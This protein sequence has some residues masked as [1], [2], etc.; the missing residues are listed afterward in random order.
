MKDCFSH[1][2]LHLAAFLNHSDLI[3]YLHH[4]GCDING[5]DC[6]HHTP[7]HLAAITDSVESVRVLIQCGAKVDKFSVQNMTPIMIAAKYNSVAVLR[8]F[9]KL[10][11]RSLLVSTSDVKT[12]LMVGIEAKHEFIVNSLLLTGV[13]PMQ[14]L[15]NGWST[16]H[17]A[18][19]S[20]SISLY[21][22]LKAAFSRAKVVFDVN[23]LCQRMKESKF[24]NLHVFSSQNS[25][26][27]ISTKSIDYRFVCNLVFGVIERSLGE[28]PSEKCEEIPSKLSN[29]EIRS[30]FSWK[31]ADSYVSIYFSNHPLSCLSYRHS[32]KTSESSIIPQHSSVYDRDFCLHI[33][34][35][36]NYTRLIFDILEDIANDRISTGSMCIN[37]TDYQGMRP[38]FYAIFH[39]NEEVVEKLIQY[40]ADVNLSQNG[41][42]PLHFAIAAQNDRI[43]RILLVHKANISSIVV[44]KS[45]IRLSPLNVATL[46][47]NRPIIFM[48]EKAI[49]R[50]R[51]KYDH[52]EDIIIGSLLSKPSYKHQKHQK[53]EYETQSSDTQ[54][55]VETLSSEHHHP[56]VSIGTVFEDKDG[57]AETLSLSE[58]VE[59]LSI[60]S[61]KSSHYKTTSNIDAGI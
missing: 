9:I 57:E 17:S 48:I 35:R 10:C 37:L 11:D 47:M 25:E 6:D 30:V 26:S 7:L 36:H 20:G 12:A 5:I 39:G 42:F 40:G 33:A 14:K 53:I 18:A 61:V 22:N 23:C 13:C 1:S 54:E 60:E 21:R 19:L 31:L 15:S 59:I 27:K 45:G 32:Q 24:P 56:T 16:I 55:F 43:V 8:E 44:T 3:K 50:S 38:L 4:C 2:L 58:S 46:L 34:C 29:K 52:K 28:D 51:L 49:E 41:I